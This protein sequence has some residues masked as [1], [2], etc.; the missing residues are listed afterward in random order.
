MNENDLKYLLASYQTTSADLFTQSVATSAKIRQLTDLVNTLS[1]KVKE[2]E[3][4]IEKLSKTKTTRATKSTKDA[5]T[6]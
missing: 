1:E 2:Q 4:E 6:F 5:G 3:K